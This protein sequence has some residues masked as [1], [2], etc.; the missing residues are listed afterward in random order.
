MNFITN[1]ID[2]KKINLLY[3]APE[4]FLL[5]SIIILLLLG[6]VQFSKNIT[7]NVFKNYF[8]FYLLCIFFLF[9]ITSFIYFFNFSIV[10]YEQPLVIFFNKTLSF[11]FAIVCFKFFIILF[12]IFCMIISK[13]YIKEQ[14]IYSF[15][16]PILILFVL[17]GS[18]FF[19]TANDL[20]VLYLAM[21]L[22]SLS[23]YILV[24]YKRTSTLSTEAGLKYII[25]GSCASGLFLF[26]SSFIYGFSGTINFTELKLL[27]FDS[28]F[29]YYSIALGIIFILVSILFK[30]GAVPFHMWIADIYEGIP[31]TITLF[32]ATIPKI[33]IFF[34]LIKFC[35]IIFYNLI[36]IWQ[37]I[38]SFCSFVSIF[39][40]TLI[41]VTQKKIKRFLAYSGIVHLGYLLLGLSTGSI[42]GLQSSLVYLILYM[43][44]NLSL[45]LIFL[46]LRTIKSNKQL[47]YLSDLSGIYKLNPTI[48]SA[49]II[50]IFSLSG[51]PPLAGFFGK[52]AI[53]EILIENSSYFLLIFSI[54]A[55]I[56]STFYYIRIIKIMCFDENI[57]IVY[58]KQF[59]IINLFI[60]FLILL[61]FIF[62]IFFNQKIITITLQIASNL[63]L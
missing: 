31:L 20:L 62:F 60:L 15:E 57:N 48:T 36:F 41:L 9:I 19:I 33:A 8:A 1:I 50:I 47:I 30:L 22:M 58:Y 23:L 25:L 26:G 42:L 32:L 38:L 7:K 55:S 5:I 12:G 51:I 39:I 29:L 54:L 44:H 53:F 49:F 40:G 6:V 11:S 16:Y 14:K 24:S 59:S 4:A 27:F 61:F 43:F 28:N 56:I 52:A 35:Y 10:S 21:E 34:F 46:S 17:L 18:L 2:F 37:P 63:I 3:I 13:D 45:W